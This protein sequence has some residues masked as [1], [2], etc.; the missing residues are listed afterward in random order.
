M[1]M[2]IEKNRFRVQWD[3]ELGKLKAILNCQ[4]PYY[5]DF[6][7]MNNKVLLAAQKEVNEK[8]DIDFSYVPLKRGTKVYAIRFTVKGMTQTV[9]QQTGFDLVHSLQEEIEDTE[10]KGM[11]ELLKDACRNEFSSEETEALLQ[12]I[13][14]LPEKKLPLP[15]EHLIDLRRYHYL[16]I[17]YTKMNQMSSRKKIPNRYRYLYT[18]IKNDCQS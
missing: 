12:L 18:M 6:K 2:Y 11:I 1:F 9:N 10:Y 3:E 4:D 15:D 16:S 5:E 14:V 13:M 17:Q 8:T 7:R